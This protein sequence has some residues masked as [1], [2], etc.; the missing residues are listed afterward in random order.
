MARASFFVFAILGSMCID[1]SSHREINSAIVTYLRSIISICII[2][3]PKLQRKY[4]A[5]L[6]RLF[7]SVSKERRSY[8]NCKQSINHLRAQ[9][10][11]VI[12]QEMNRC[13]MLLQSNY[14]HQQNNKSIPLT[15]GTLNRFLNFII[16]FGVKAEH[17]A[18]L[19]L[20][21]EYYLLAKELGIHPNTITFNFLLKANRFCQGGV[22][23]KLVVVH[24]NEM[25]A[26]GIK[27]DSYT[28]IELLA[29]C[30]RH[31]TGRTHG[32]SIT[33]KQVAD[34]EFR[35]YRTSVFPFETIKRKPRYTTVFNVYL[36]V[37]A[38]SGDVEGMMRLLD[39]AKRSGI[40]FKPRAEKRNFDIFQ[41]GCLV[42]QMFNVSK[43]NF[44]LVS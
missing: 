16:D 3:I 27:A 44:D 40:C 7:Q 1:S 39:F 13:L 20:V 5:N 12:E 21:D 26:C 31:P 36:D 28:I 17:G 30:A 6:H 11:P 32:G 14:H 41:T 4:D 19:Q 23:G 10:W 43:I 25:I 8:L 24:L 35:Y 29:M 37:Y 22:R 34:A 42:S 15:I 2:A 38:K 18:S 33:N 9:Y